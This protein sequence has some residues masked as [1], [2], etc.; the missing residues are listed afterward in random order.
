MRL[1]KTELLELNQILSNRKHIKLPD[2]RRVVDASGRNY[3][4]IKSNI[5]KFNASYVNSNLRL[6]E[7]LDLN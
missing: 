7:L 5:C 1:T 3:Q 6:Q 2:F 4:W